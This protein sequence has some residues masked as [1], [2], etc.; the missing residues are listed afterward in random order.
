MPKPST[1]PNAQ[2]E[3]ALS[4]KAYKKIHKLLKEGLQVEKLLCYGFPLGTLLI[5]IKS[6]LIPLISKIPKLDVKEWTEISGIYRP[7]E[8]RFHSVLNILIKVILPI[9]L[10]LQNLFL[11]R[12]V[13][14]GYLVV[15]S[16]K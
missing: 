2:H 1:S 10:K 12:D 5:K 16:K 11:N 8:Q 9:Q 4:E 3:K 15:A 13:G 14:H 6:P 7:L